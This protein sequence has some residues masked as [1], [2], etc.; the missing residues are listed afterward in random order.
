MKLGVC[1]ACARVLQLGDDGRM[2]AHD[3]AG[4]VVRKATGKRRHRCPGSGRP[5]RRVER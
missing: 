3:Q 1:D 2:P 4:P 5:P